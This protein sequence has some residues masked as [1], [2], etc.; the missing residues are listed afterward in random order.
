MLP[1]RPP[2]EVE[3]HQETDHSAN[4]PPNVTARLPKANNKYPHGSYPAAVRI[5]LC[6]RLDTNLHPH[7]YRL[8]DTHLQRNIRTV[9][10]KRKR[11]CAISVHQIPKRTPA[12]GNRYLKTA[13]KKNYQ[14][15]SS[16]FL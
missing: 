2:A 9:I 6:S 1:L 7:G 12:D 13:R 16:L 14:K 8:A 15:I 5:Q 3:T 11:G 4:K 10:A